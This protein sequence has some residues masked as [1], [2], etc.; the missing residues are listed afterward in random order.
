M[1]IF[2]GPLFTIWRSSWKCWLNLNYC[3]YVHLYIYHY[4]CFLNNFKETLKYWNMRVGHGIFI[5]T[6]WYDN[7]TYFLRHTHRT[8]SDWYKLH[9][10]SSTYISTYVFLPCSWIRA[11]PNNIWMTSPQLSSRSLLQLQNL[12]RSVSL[13]VVCSPVSLCW[14]PQSATPGETHHHG[15]RKPILLFLPQSWKWTTTLNERN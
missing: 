1:L 8:E 7:G 6:I 13:V 2:S 11:N 9:T 4:I 3:T 10:H 14:F 5:C 12:P 15:N